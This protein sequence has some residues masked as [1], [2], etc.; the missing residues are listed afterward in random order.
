MRRAV[1]KAARGPAGPGL[2]WACFVAAAWSGAATARAASA[3]V[4][5]PAE[6]PV[7]IVVS[8]RTSTLKRI[9][10]AETGQAVPPNFSGGRVKNTPGYTW[11]VSRHY[12]LK[13]DYTPQ[14]ARFY[15]TL[16]EMAYPHYVA[17]FGR[18]PPGI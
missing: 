18:E 17:L 15:L 2:V 16:L 11:Y 3:P 9:A 4:P 6:T 1:R 14:R 13:T 10:I 5:P 8:G 7:E 12:A